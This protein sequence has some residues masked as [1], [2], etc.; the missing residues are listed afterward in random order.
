MPPRPY[1]PAN[2]HNSVAEKS[3]SKIIAFLN[4]AILDGRDPSW[5]AETSCYE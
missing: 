1:V 2:K 3:G 5:R 4:A